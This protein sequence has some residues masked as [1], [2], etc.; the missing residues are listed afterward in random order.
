MRVIGI[1]PGPT[2]SAYVLYDG[3]R[4]LRCGELTNDVM[5]ARLSDLDLEGT[6]LS[7]E[8][9]VS[10]GRPVGSDIF[11]TVF[12]SGR[13]IQMWEPLPWTRVAFR[14]VGRH[15]CNAASG[16]KESHVRQALLDRFGPSRR[17]AIG[18]RKQPG[19]L[20]G[21]SGHGWSALAVAVTALDQFL[22]PAA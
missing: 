9:I 11:E 10:Y 6:L 16:I 13:F 17:E 21:V 4:V 3:E 1:D 5:L 12:W 20:Y 18:I 22:T 15:L 19:P 14:D 7:V 2:I 8:Q